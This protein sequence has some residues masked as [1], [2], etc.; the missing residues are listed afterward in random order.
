MSFSAEQ[1]AIETRFSESWAETTPIAFENV[2]YTPRDSAWVRL[3]VITGEGRQ[4]SMGAATA[5]DRYTG[6]IS[7]E[8]F[9]PKNTGGR[10][11]RDLADTARAIFNRQHFG[12][13]HCRTASISQPVHDSAWHMLVVSVPYWR[14][15]IS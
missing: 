1:Q 12:G 15:Q 4:A 14:D 11:A 13:I 6:V 9:T 3:T 2:A 7:I 10:Q 5:I 8:V